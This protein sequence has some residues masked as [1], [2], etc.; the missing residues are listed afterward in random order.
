MRVNNALEYIKIIEADNARGKVYCKEC[1][2]C[3]KTDPEIDW[4]PIVY[5]CLHKEGISSL[6]VQS[7]DYCSKGVRK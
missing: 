4:K 1:I 7:M 3:E 5:R 2:Y 6:Y